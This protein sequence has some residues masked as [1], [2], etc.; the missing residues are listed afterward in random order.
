MCTFVIVLDQWG[1]TGS[2]KITRFNDLQ[3]TFKGLWNFIPFKFNCSI[4]DIITLVAKYLI[5]KIN[6]ISLWA[7]LSLKNEFL[8]LANFKSI[9]ILPQMLNIF[10][11]LHFVI[12]YRCNAEADTMPLW[13]NKPI[14]TTCQIS[15]MPLGYMYLCQYSKYYYFLLNLC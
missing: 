2:Q 10:Y 8:S 12:H 14:F 7:N 3:H 5:S 4:L 1:G 15:I 13:L 11:F 6:V 9:L